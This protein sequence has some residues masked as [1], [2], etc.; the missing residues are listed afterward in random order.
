VFVQDSTIEPAA[1]PAGTRSIPVRR[2]GAEVDTAELARVSTD[3]LEREIGELTAH[4]SAATCRWLL[5]V[6]EFDRR[7]GY[8][9]W[10]CRSCAQWLSW[11]CGVAIRS[12]QEKLRVARRLG[13]L[14]AVTAAFSRGELS[15]SK[16]RALARVATSETEAELLELALHATAA[17]LER[18]TRAYRG[19]ATAGEANDAHDRRFLEYSW[20]DD[21]SLVF[22]GRLAAEEG[23]LLLKALEAGRDECAAADGPQGDSEERSAE[24]PTRRVSSADAL[25]AVAESALASADA[26]SSGGDRHQ[27][28]VQLDAAALA[29]AGEVA[30]GS[31]GL[32]DGPALAPE[33][34]RRLA[35]DC[36]LVASVEGRDGTLSVGRKTRTIPPSV[37]RALRAR[38][39]GCRFPGCTA[40]R[41]LD[42]HHLIAWALGGETSLE[43][44]ILLCRHHH[45]L[46]HEGGFTVELRPGGRL[47]FRRPDGRSVPH[48]P[49]PHEGRGR[50][51]VEGNRTRRLRL[52]P[53]SCAARSPGDRLDYDLAVMGLFARGDPWTAA[54]P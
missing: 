42:A 34:I 5:L 12:A 28:V 20:E 47:L 14:P 25:V 13:E 43:N 50:T 11:R 38:D 23:A 16:A 24:R 2:A 26:A 48:S 18:L 41:F 39:R 19:A 15:Y 31:C 27:L 40:H 44:L 52:D 4:I 8:L 1:A 17:Q 3:R 10:G 37:R 6:A 7:E 30:K 22:S 51:I 49:R 46:L 32:E 9:A 29:A 35:C 21:G 36:S 53:E 33:T 54:E 45:R